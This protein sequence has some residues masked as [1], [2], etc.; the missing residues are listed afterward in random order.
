[1]R[2]LLGYEPA[3]LSVHPSPKTVEGGFI[4]SYRCLVFPQNVLKRKHLLFGVIQDKRA[5]KGVFVH[6]HSN[7]ILINLTLFYDT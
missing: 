4:F 3:Y 7:K 5:K 1:M 6:I 2:K